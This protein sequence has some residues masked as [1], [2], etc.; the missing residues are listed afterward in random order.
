MKLE[1]SKSETSNLSVN[2]C[3]DFLLKRKKT[4][5]NYKDSYLIK[6]LAYTLEIE[7]GKRKSWIEKISNFEEK[8]HRRI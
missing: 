4:K 5:K 6:K 8:L 1:R 3:F 2:K 7:Q